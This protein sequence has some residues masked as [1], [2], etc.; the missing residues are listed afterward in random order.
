[1]S[2]EEP[3]YHTIERCK[4]CMSPH[5]AFIETQVYV[6][7]KPLET[8]LEWFKANPQF[9]FKVSKSSFWSHFKFHVNKTGFLEQYPHWKSKIDGF[10]CKNG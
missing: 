1:M 8:T 5:R 7:G 3:R 4:T 6:M 2:T 10:G 9:G